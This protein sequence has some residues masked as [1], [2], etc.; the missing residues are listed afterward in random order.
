MIAVMLNVSLYNAFHIDADLHCKT[1][2]SLTDI[3]GNITSY[4]Q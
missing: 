2:I 4:Y 1:N 3:N